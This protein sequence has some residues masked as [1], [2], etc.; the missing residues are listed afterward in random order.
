MADLLIGTAT[1][2]VNGLAAFAN[3]AP[4]TYKYV[5]STARTGY[6]ADPTEYTITVTNTTPVTADRSNSPTESGSITI[7]KHALGY[8][9]LVLS[10]ATFK[11]MDSTGKTMQSVTAA[12][13]AD[14]EIALTDLMSMTGTPQT[15]KLLE[16]TP[17]ANYNLNTTEFTPSVTVGADSAQAVPNT[18]TVAGSLDVTLTDTNYNEYGLT[19][20]DYDL[21]LVTP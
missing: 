18:P 8:P 14:G 9:A 1:T 11:L 10:G 20:A 16:V 17:P 13:D 21:Y 15:Y 12:S 6:T 5:Q 3:L 4:G 2:D 7:N 19:G